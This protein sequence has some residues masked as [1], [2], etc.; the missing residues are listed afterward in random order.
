MFPH[1]CWNET[2]LKRNYFLHRI[3]RG[4]E[5]WFYHFD[6]DTEWH[7][8]EWKHTTP[9][10]KKESTTMSSVCNNMVTI[11]DCWRLH[12]GQVFAARGNHQCCS[13]PSDAPEALSSTVWKMFGEKDDRPTIWQCK[14]P[15]CSCVYWEDSE[16][17]LGG[18]PLSPY[19]LDLAP[20]D[21]HHSS[22]WSI[23]C[24]NNG[25]HLSFTNCWNRVLPQGNLHTSTAV[26]KTHWSAWYFAEK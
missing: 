26:V 20:M 15:H 23:R 6:P 16:E 5:N 14:A 19:S 21:C 18:F 22:L 13:L 2:M 11:L 7:S 24:A 17:W 3:M 12:V 9:P 25:S 8:M 1:N 10:K 4:C